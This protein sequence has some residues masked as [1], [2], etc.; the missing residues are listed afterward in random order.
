[1]DLL[2]EYLTTS[3]L[4]ADTSL[5]H[6][7]DSES[8]EWEVT[9]LIWGFIRALQPEVVLETGSAFGQTTRAIARALQEN[10][11]G[12]LHSVDFTPDRVET[13]NASLVDA[14]L[15]RFAH[16]HLHDALTWEPP[17]GTVFGFVFL[18]SDLKTR[19]QEFHHYRRWMRPYTVVGMHDMDAY[20]EP[21][22]GGRSRVLPLI[23]EGQLDAFFLPT[24]RGVC[25]GVVR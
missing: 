9:D 19:Y 13:V 2:P 10:G 14:G 11:H 21:M 4:V 23:A 3:E 6:S 12:F 5:W 15:D 20:F 18:D 17:E 24:P 22:G 7:T 1:V 8:T 25:F 16:V